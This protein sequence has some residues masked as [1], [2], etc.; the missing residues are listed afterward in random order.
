MCYT[1][2]GKDRDIVLEPLRGFPAIRDF[3]VDKSKTRD[4]IAK[5][6]ARVRSKP[7]VQSDITAKMDPALAKKIGN[8]EWC[9][10]CL[11]L[12]CRLPGY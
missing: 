2:V 4:R 9:C 3:I 5:I 7:L 6:E 10:R 11:K 8:L 12:Y 1:P